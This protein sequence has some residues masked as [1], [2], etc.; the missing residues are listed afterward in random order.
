MLEISPPVTR[1]ITFLIVLGP[2]KVAVWPVAMPNVS[3]LWNRLSPRREPRSAP[4]STL[5]PDR[6][7]LGPTEPS[8][9]ICAW[10]GPAASNAAISGGPSL[11][12]C[13]RTPSDIGCL[14]NSVTCYQ[15]CNNRYSH[16]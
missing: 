11:C 1:L 2:V 14:G 8:V 10:T 3:K 15:K 13:E 16:H 9:T 5:D 12:L 7:T 6:L 4:M